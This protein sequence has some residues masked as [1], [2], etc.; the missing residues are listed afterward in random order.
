MCQYIIHLLLYSLSR[1]VNSRD[2]EYVLNSTTMKS[3]LSLCLSDHRSWHNDSFLFEEISQGL[4]SPKD[5]VGT[6]RDCWFNIEHNCAD[7]QQKISMS[8][9]NSLT[10]AIM[11][12]QLRYVVFLVSDEI[13]KFPL[14]AKKKVVPRPPARSSHTSASHVVLM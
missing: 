9:G 11:Q 8:Y 4:Y 12:W 2:N 6:R 1:K 10:L 13:N 3:S 5:E 14:L 7:F